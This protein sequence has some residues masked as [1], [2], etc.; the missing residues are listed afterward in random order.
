MTD[1]CCSVCREIGGPHGV[2]EPIP[3]GE[4][5]MKRFK[6]CPNGE[7]HYLMESCP[8]GHRIVQY[9]SHGADN[10][11]RADAHV[12]AAVEAERKQLDET[13]AARGYGENVRAG[14]PMWITL[15][16]G[17]SDGSTPS[18]PAR[19][20]CPLSERVDGPLHSWRFD[21][22]DPYVICVYCDRMQDART[23]RVIR[24]G[25]TS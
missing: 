15:Y 16:G 2:P 3:E 20:D 8:C 24:E 9:E 25:R 12:R 22:D 13:L 14:D 4:L 6:A 21:G 10:R 18:A 23:G 1:P 11:Q 7:K 17:V 19:L 5:R